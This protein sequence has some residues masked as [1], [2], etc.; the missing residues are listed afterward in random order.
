MEAVEI[1]EIAK[2][3]D[4]TV[5]WMR[6]YIFRRISAAHE[7]IVDNSNWYDVVSCDFD[8]DLMRITTVLKRI[9]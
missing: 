6:P 3:E 1:T 5:V 2:L 8:K 4:G 9:Q 7:T